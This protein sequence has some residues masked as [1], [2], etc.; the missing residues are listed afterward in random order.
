MQFSSTGALRLVIIAILVICTPG[1][2]AA[3]A[4]TLEEAESLAVARDAGVAGIEERSAALSEAAVADQQLPDPELRFGAVNLPVDSFSLDD[5]NMTQ[6][7]VGLRQ[8]IPRGKTRS[9]RRER[10]ESMAAAEFAMA[11]DRRREVVRAVRNTWIERAFVTRA[12]AI[13]ERQQSWFHQLE[14]AATAAY[15]SGGRRQH[16]LFRIAMERELLEEDKERL[17][18]LGRSWDAEL[19]RWLGPQA[20]PADPSDI[21]ELPSPPPRQV[22]AATLAGH[23]V[24]TAQ[25]RRAEAGKFGVDLARQQSRPNWAI[26]VSYGFRQGE[27][28]AGDDRPDFF[29]AMLSFDMPIFPKNRQDRRVSAAMATEL[30]MKSLLKD[31]QRVLRRSFES[32]WADENVLEQRVELFE[33]R[34]L[35]SAL[36]NVE[37][38]RQAYR[39]DVVLFDELV[40]SEKSLLDTRMRL[41]RLRA[42]HA[43]STAE[44]LYLTGESR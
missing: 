18:Q 4:L 34:V 2:A 27:D 10:T 12:I 3:A 11:E 44:L 29:S 14:D 42:D 16:E 43:L 30:E 7:L 38:T 35:P 5:Q 24:L 22:A 32:A 36:A 39:N 6:I 41:L 17:R 1:L 37:A 9:L 21:P 23:P 31:R 25:A 40:R 33:N 8:R 26:D 28:R 15:A 13:V 19:E 20:G